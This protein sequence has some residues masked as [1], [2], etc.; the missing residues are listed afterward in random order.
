VEYVRFVETRYVLEHLDLHSGDCVLDIGSP[1]L[2]SLYLAARLGV[3]MHAT[4]LVDYFF[5]RYSTYADVAHC[6]NRYW[7]EA[8]DG[9]AMP[10]ADASFDRAFSISAIEH[11]PG[12]GDS[13]AIAEIG[14]VLKPGG[15][16]CLTVPWCDRG[17]LEEFKKVS[18]VY[19]VTP[20]EHQDQV[21]YQRAYDR[22][23]LLSRLV[24]SGPFTLVDLTFWGE[25]RVPME[26]WIQHPSLPKVVRWAVLPAHLPL[27]RMFLSPL[28]ENE[29]SRKKVAC[30]TLRR[31]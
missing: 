10:Y 22:P 16:L 2:L 9:R 26:H 4:D 20:P 5:E 29:P 28:E 21:F 24:H 14:R 12:D 18:D 30:L 15:V 11:I 13:Q 25:R 27:S 1:K 7:M 17:Y 3:N 31:N 8:V 6:R 23:S 19:W